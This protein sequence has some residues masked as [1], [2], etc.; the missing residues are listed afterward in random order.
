MAPDVYLNM[1]RG[2][3]G[4]AECEARNIR[5]RLRTFDSALDRAWEDRPPLATPRR[6]VQVFSG[7]AMPSQPDHFYLTHPVELDGTEV[8]GSTAPPVVDTSVTIPVDVL[9]SAPHVGDILT[10]Y[11]VGGRW[12]AERGSGQSTG[13]PCA[14]CTIPARNLIVSWTNP[15]IGN[16]STT[17]VYNSSTQTWTSGCSNELIYQLLC[18]SG[19][20]EFRAIYF[21]SGPCPSGT[22]QYC[23]NLRPNPFGLTQTGLTCGSSFLMTMTCQSACPVLQLD[24][25]TGFTVSA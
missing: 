7:G 3:K 24:G 13:V 23:S 20:V 1:P 25:F 18:S 16:G 9:W 5:E 22:Q 8:E 11:A 12:V 2:A 14:H 10:A 4:S 21:I 17:L 15:I 19:Q 6:L